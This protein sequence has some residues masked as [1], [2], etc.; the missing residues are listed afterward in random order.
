MTRAFFASC[1]RVACYVRGNYERHLLK[2]HRIKDWRKRA[3]VEGLAGA[4]LAASV[5]D[6]VQ[7]SHDQTRINRLRVHDG[8]TRVSTSHDMIR[9]SCSQPHQLNIK[10]AVVVSRVRLQTFFLENPWYFVVTVPEID[11]RRHLERPT[12]APLAAQLDVLGPLDASCHD[13]GSQA[14]LRDHPVAAADAVPRISPRPRSHRVH[15]DVQ[16]SED[17]RGQRRGALPRV[18]QRSPGPADRIAKTR[19]RE[20]AT[21]V[22]YRPGTAEQ[23]LAQRHVSEAATGA[24]RRTIA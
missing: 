13:P 19:Q 11:P 6:V 21:A 14:Y 24:R 5:T 7:P 15:G 10:M 22:P 3:V 9:Q 1:S 17:G 12:A 20:K 23:L 8:C 16:G 4:N 2:I 18:L